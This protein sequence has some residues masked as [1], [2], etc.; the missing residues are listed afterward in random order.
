MDDVQ[1]HVDVADLLAGDR[2]GYLQ[3]LA[4]LGAAR[5]RECRREVLIVG[6]VLAVEYVVAH[7]AVQRVVA[8]AA[9]GDVVAQAARQG[10]VPAAPDLDCLN[11]SAKK[12]GRSVF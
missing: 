11:G 12:L 5:D 4:R 9:D 7:P 8:R 1:P 6:P 2:D 3:A 10:V